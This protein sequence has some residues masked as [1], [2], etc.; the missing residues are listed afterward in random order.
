[1][2]ATRAA[3]DTAVEDRSS[4][5]PVIPLEKIAGLPAF[6]D[7]AV[8]RLMEEHHTLGTAIAVVHDGRILLLRG[9]GKARLDSGTPI[10]PAR[11]L[12]RIGSVTKLFTAAA[13][14]Q[15]AE[16]GRLDLHRDV[17]DYLPDIPLRYHTT[18]HHLLTH[19]ASLDE[20]FGGGYTEA[21]QHLQSLRDHLRRY[22]RQFGPPG[23]AYIYSNTNYALAGLVVET[24]SGKSFEDYLAGHIFRPLGMDRT[25]AYQ[26]PAAHLV[27]DVARGYVWD[28]GGHRAMPF[29]L[30]QSRPAGAI[31]ATVADIAQF[32]LAVLG[33]GATER[34]RLLSADSTKTY[35][36]EHFTPDPRIPAM[37]YGFSHVLT[38]GQ[39]QL[40]RGGTLGDHVSMTLLIPAARLGLFVA[41]NGVT[42]IGD[43][44][45]EPLMTHLAGPTSPASSPTPLPDVVQRA[46][47]FAGMFRDYHHTRHDL[48]RLRALMPMIQSPVVADPD[49]A[50]RWRGRR[51]IEVEPMVFQRVD[52]RDFIVF[53]EGADGDIAELHASGATY[54][55]VGWM[56]H[57]YFHVGVLAASLTAFLLIAISRLRRWWQEGGWRQDGCRAAKAARRYA[58]FVAVVNLMFIVGLAVQI[59]DLGGTTPLPLPTLFLLL[60]PLISLA[61]TLV[62]P[63]YAV[64]AWRDHWWTL[65]ERVS[66][67]L[68]AG[69]A[70][71][72]MTFLNYWKLLGF[73][74]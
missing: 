71:V 55:R 61:V 57:R 59:G 2:P 37:A 3:A 9:Y 6:I 12:F 13:A 8:P 66:Y 70:I 24:L 68:V 49:G 69:L 36:A 31:S 48:S 73:R 74:Y 7:T 25:D 1:M 50:I 63:A 52:A 53:R 72:F 33:D 64:T 19:T 10:D 18:T 16:T 40:Y 5:S 32:M 54:E 14:V 46:P 67:S 60:L 38:Y 20:K 65:R 29:R 56:E 47:R 34:A 4:A 44:L 26:P 41:S 27:G 23:N 21:P 17:R 42:G 39:R 15:L 28:K 22:V 43:F 58:V 51:W 45:Y 62:L 35:L 11:T 30:T